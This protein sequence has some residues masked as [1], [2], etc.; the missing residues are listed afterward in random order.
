[1]YQ[2]AANAM[3][4]ASS[5]PL[6]ILARVGARALLERV[7]SKESI[8][9]GGFLFQVVAC[10]M[11]Q[12]SCPHYQRPFSIGDTLRHSLLV[13]FKQRSHV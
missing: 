5:P 10:G 6:C 8:I 2:P 1:M 7:Q 11:K 9:D 4:L 12:L 3:F 13:G